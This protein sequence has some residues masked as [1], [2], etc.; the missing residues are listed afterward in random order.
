MDIFNQFLCRSVWHLYIN[1][2]EV[3]SGECTEEKEYT[4]NYDKL[5]VKDEGRFYVEFTNKVDYK[6]TIENYTFVVE[7]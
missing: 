3:L 7:E 1:D 4:V 5:D 6:Q 2:I